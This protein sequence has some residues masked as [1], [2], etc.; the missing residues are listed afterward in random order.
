MLFRWIGGGHK[1]ALSFKRVAR[2][3]QGS[4][5]GYT[6]TD[7][8][9]YTDKLIFAS[10]QNLLK[11]ASI[12]PELKKAAMKLGVAHAVLPCATLAMNTY[13]HFRAR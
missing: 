12:A 10:G 9:S 1:S 13:F 6:Y 7:S 3:P 2:C 5:A 11:L 4:T 8:M